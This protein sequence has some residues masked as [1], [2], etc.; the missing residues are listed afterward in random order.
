VDLLLLLLQIA[1]AVL[2]V[3]M[4]LFSAWD[5]WQ[6]WSAKRRV[7]A[8]AFAVGIAV[9]AFSQYQ[10]IVHL[11]ERSLENVI[12]NVGLLH[13][14][15]YARR[16]VVSVWEYVGVAIA[17][18]VLLTLAWDG[19]KRRRNSQLLASSAVFLLMM[20]FATMLKLRTWLE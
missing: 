5:K 18:A 17:G 15:W 6:T 9:V 8:V 4:P 1:L 10:R 11:H 20:A 3:V 16:V 2:L 13:G 7:I 19:Y 14:P 12:G